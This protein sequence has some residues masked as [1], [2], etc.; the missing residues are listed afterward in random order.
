M[1]AVLAY[2]PDAVLSHA[3]AAALWGF[4]KREPRGI[5]VSLPSPGGRT[6]QPG[7]AVH[8]RTV[9]GPG[10]V[11]RY[12]NIPVTTPTATLVDMAARLGGE[13]LEAMVNEAVMLHRVDLEELRSAVEGLRRPGARTLRA[14]IDRQTFRLTRS[15]L[16]RLFLPIAKQA[17]LPMPETRA[18]VNGY[19]VDFWWPELKLVVETD[20]GEFHRTPRQQTND[21]QRE[22]AHIR[23]GLQCIRFTHYQVAHER[24]EVERTL[25]SAAA[26]A[27]RARGRTPPLR[28]G[29]PRR[30][31]S[32]PP[33]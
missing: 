1:A 31:S 32:A 28:A 22:H 21:R 13:A 8:R 5:E 18:I 16:E 2:E 25:V 7:V 19:E 15:K 10:D 12:R 30:R 14:L 27:A 20:G 9:L 33:S 24:N 23:T 11:T 26:Q 29:R 4:G 6:A 17:G 3:S